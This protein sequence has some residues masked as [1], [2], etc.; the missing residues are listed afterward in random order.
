ML[1]SATNVFP[2]EIM[3]KSKFFFIGRILQL[4]EV[5]SDTFALKTSSEDK[6]VWTIM[7]H[8]DLLFFSRLVSVLMDLRICLAL[9]LP[10]ILDLV[11]FSLS[12]MLW[13]YDCETKLVQKYRCKLLD[14][15]PMESWVKFCTCQSV[16]RIGHII[17]NR[18]YLYF[19]DCESIIFPFV[20]G[21]I[22]CHVYVWACEPT[23]DEVHTSTF[24]SAATVKISPW[25]EITLGPPGF[26]ETW[27]KLYGAIL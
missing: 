10:E 7:S 21:P 14:Y 20:S 1:R 26:S 27:N 16:I 6:P 11:T 19:Y 25:E 2:T 17:Y 3:M 9:V 18:S 22:D 24:S 4:L 5:Q 12:S 15:T 13:V 23:S 8:Y